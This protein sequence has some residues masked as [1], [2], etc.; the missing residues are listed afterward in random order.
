MKQLILASASPRRIN[1]LATIG[2]HAK[3]VSSRFEEIKNNDLRP[4]QLVVENALGKAKEVAVRYKNSI[5][6]GADTMVVLKGTMLGKPQSISEAYDML[7]K[8]SGTSHTV[9]TGIAVVDAQSNKSVTK[10]VMTKVW[11]KKLSAIEIESY[12][13][14]TNPFDKAGAYGIQE[15]AAL[16]ITKIEGDYFNVVGLPLYPLREL[17]IQFG[18]ELL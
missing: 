11:F 14:S 13:K 15:K 7:K 2:I 3:V 10:T 9:C 4:E 12:I 5:V 16:F 6:I 17:L 18:V 1:L 8:L